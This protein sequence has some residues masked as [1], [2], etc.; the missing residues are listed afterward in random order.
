MKKIN[1]K[2]VTVIDDTYN[3]N[4]DSMSSSISLLG[5]V[6]DKRKIAILGDMLELG[7]Y[8]EELHTK[9][10]DVVVNNNVDILVT[11]GEWSLNIEK[12][13]IELGMDSNNCYHFA[14]LL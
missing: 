3:A 1:N 4:F 12:R 14:Q 13:A 8:S 7:D 10:G 9:L 6:I 2:G 11:V 5:K